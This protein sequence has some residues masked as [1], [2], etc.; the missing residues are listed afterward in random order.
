MQRSIA[1]LL[2]TLAIIASPLHAQSIRGKVTDVATGKPIATA[3]VALID[4]DGSLGSAAT[5]DASGMFFLRIPGSDSVRVRVSRLGYANVESIPLGIAVGDTLHL[6]VGL[7]P[8]P[9]EIAG[10]TATAPRTADHERFLARQRTGFG[11]YL[12]PEDIEKMKPTSTATLL[13]GMPNAHL[14]L[15]SSG[16][17]IVAK[18]RDQRLSCVPAVYVDGDLLEEDSPANQSTGFTPFRSEAP[19]RDGGVRIDA[20]VRAESVRAVE[21]YRNP[22]QAPPEFQQAF[23]PDCA[24]VVIWTTHGFGARP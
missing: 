23:M 8:V 11:Q 20:F 16:R 24:V 1:T 14:R 10:V 4:A 2:V 7:R 6:D 5:T 19:T 3:L 12:G 18:P 15:G 21:V 13:V 22:A 17:T 9:V